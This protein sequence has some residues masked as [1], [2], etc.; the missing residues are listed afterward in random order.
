MTLDRLCE[1]AYM[2]EY[3]ELEEL[4]E[5]KEFTKTWNNLLDVQLEDIHLSRLDL[6]DKDFVSIGGIKL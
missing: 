3:V 2:C 6:E 5:I 1:L 4:G